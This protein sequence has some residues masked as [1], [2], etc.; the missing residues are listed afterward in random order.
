MQLLSKKVMGEDKARSYRPHERERLNHRPYPKV[1][2]QKI[3]DKK[4][5]QLG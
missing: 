3:D 2:R 4:P 5:T 1:E